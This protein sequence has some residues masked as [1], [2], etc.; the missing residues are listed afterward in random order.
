MGFPVN[1]L[2]T[3]GISLLTSDCLTG[4]R[5]KSSA[6]SSKHLLILEGIFS[7]DIIT[8]G[9]SFKYDDSCKFMFLLSLLVQLGLISH[10]KQ[11][12]ERQSSILIGTSSKK[13]GKI[14]NLISP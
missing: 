13:T 2:G 6:P 11:V 4:L 9:M 1:E 10:H 8:T 7:E 5:K 3:S 12:L 14:V